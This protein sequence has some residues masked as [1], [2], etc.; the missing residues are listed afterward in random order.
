MKINGLEKMLLISAIG[1]SIVSAS[2]FAS[3]PLSADGIEYS[4]SLRVQSTESRRDALRRQPMR[5]SEH[6]NLRDQ[7]L[8]LGK[9]QQARQSSLALAQAAEEDAEKDLQQA[10]KAMKAS[11]EFVDVLGQE[12]TLLGRLQGTNVTEYALLSNIVYTAFE[13]RDYPKT[14]AS[15]EVQEK[16]TRTNKMI[17][18]LERLAKDARDASGARSKKALQALQRFMGTD[19]DLVNTLDQA[20]V[21]IGKERLDL[22]ALNK[23]LET[24]NDVHIQ[25]FQNKLVGALG[26][27]YKVEGVFFRNNG[28]I[29]GIAVYDNTAK[30]LVLAF[31]GSKS[32]LDWLKNFFGWNAKANANHG[33]LQGM[34][35]HAG[36]LSHFE[37]MAEST[38][39]GI[40][41]WFETYK[42][43]YSA[44]EE[45]EIVGTGHSLGGALAEMATAAA[46]KIALDA[47]VKVKVGAVTFGAPSILNA[48]SLAKYHQ[49]MG[50]A[51]NIVRI[52]D[53]WDLVPLAVF[54]KTA[55]GIS[56][57]INSGLFHDSTGTFTPIPRNAHSANDY[58]HAAEDAFRDWKTSVECLKSK[59]DAHACAR[60]EVE[61]QT[62]E[63]VAL[64]ESLNSKFS[65]LADADELNAH[66]FQR[67]AAQELNRLLDQRDLRKGTLQPLKATLKSRRSQQ[68]LTQSVIGFDGYIAQAKHLQR[69]ILAIDARV[70]A[71]TEELELWTQKAEELKRKRDAEIDAI[72][73]EID[74]PSLVSV[75]KV[76]VDNVS[77]AELEKST[78]TV[79]VPTKEE[80]ARALRFTQKQRA[81]PA[82]QCRVE[83]E[84][85]LEGMRGMHFPIAV[86]G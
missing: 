30:K 17:E 48:N 16:I 38:L 77:E 59:I 80:I 55:P 52:E 1:V 39:A 67:D 81:L 20:T 83:A 56:I 10:V 7:I 6:T 23:K 8:D 46:K 73:A 34:N 60:L 14:K 29:S 40:R 58:Y 45:L 47:G 3:V 51:A 72:L 2:S 24:T 36:F 11:Q 53:S 75:E 69:E 28:E 70:R 42:A 57:S 63:V 68:D 76:D 41:T 65:V 49:L 25:F 44:N 84:T 71:L 37:D 74:S 50:G 66:I 61:K 78:W 31:A 85:F 82:Y 86:A 18:T 4:E 27:R 12:G 5:L 33:C 21:R 79:L 26:N 43:K 22:E 9:A 62:E 13:T 35:F 54:W 32:R 64:A 15:L 19:S